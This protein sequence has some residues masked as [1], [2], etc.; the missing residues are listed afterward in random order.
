MTLRRSLLA[1]PFLAVGCAGVH[2]PDSPPLR[3]AVALEQANASIGQAIARMDAFETLARRETAAIAWEARAL[4]IAPCESA[5]PG[6]SLA[7]RH[8]VGSASL[9]LVGHAPPGEPR[10]Q[11][12]GS[13]RPPSRALRFPPWPLAC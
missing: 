4:P 9:V 3:F 1:L 5:P 7:A 12:R 13:K 11:S 2:A 10:R 8:H 6:A